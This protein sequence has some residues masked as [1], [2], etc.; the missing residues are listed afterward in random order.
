MKQRKGIA[1]RL[2]SV[3]ASLIESTYK[4]S[5]SLAKKATRSWM[6]LRKATLTLLKGKF[7]E[8]EL[9]AL[10]SIA[11]SHTF[12][13]DRACR[14]DILIEDIKEDTAVPH[15]LVDAITTLSPAEIFF[16]QDWMYNFW[17]RGKEPVEEYIKVLL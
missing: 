9:L 14:K 11:H 6:H 3:D 1:F 10:I 13:I 5:N 17:E 4:N 15:R 12:N 7:T 8:N 16:L 2:D